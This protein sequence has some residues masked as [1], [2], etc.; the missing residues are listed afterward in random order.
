MYNTRYSC[1]EPEDVED[2]V[3]SPMVDMAAIENDPLV[4]YHLEV[5]GLKPMVDWVASGC[6]T[7]GIPSVIILDCAEMFT[8]FLLE[9]PQEKKDLEGTPYSESEHIEHNMDNYGYVNYKQE[10]E[11]L[12]RNSA[13]FCGECIALH[14][15]FRF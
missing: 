1:A 8:S 9:V 7:R 3:R 6:Q 12:F 2:H 5:I 15:K 10:L 11:P 13:V 4:M 14:Y